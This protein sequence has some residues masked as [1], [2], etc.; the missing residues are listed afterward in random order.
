MA[1]YVDW[2][3]PGRVLYVVWPQDITWDI[4]AET[5]DVLLA[6]LDES[7]EPVHVVGDARFADEVQVLNLGLRREKNV[8]EHDMLGWTISIAHRAA[9]E[10]LGNA[11]PQ[12]MKVSLY[13]SFETV[14]DAL[15]FLNLQDETLD[16]D[17]AN[18][19][20]I[21]ASAYH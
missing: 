7:A 17:T 2:L 5:S 21:P 15:V 1:L 16:W 3:I 12:H 11:L 19:D 13:R 18:H 9:L 10:M 6:C 14:D 8:I 4:L 20:V